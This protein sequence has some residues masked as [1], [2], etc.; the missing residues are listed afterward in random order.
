M[1]VMMACPSLIRNSTP[2]IKGPGA[3]VLMAAGASP[4][5]GQQAKGRRDNTRGTRLLT[6]P[7]SKSVW[8]SP[9]PRR[10][11]CPPHGSHR[12][13]QS[14][15]PPTPCPHAHI[16]QHTLLPNTPLHP[17]SLSFMISFTN[18]LIAP[19][20]THPPVL[21]SF[22][23]LPSPPSAHLLLNLPSFSISCYVRWK[24]IIM[25][26]EGAC[27]CCSAITMHTH[28]HTCMQTLIWGVLGWGLIGPGGFGWG[29]L[30]HWFKCRQYFLVVLV[31]EGVAG[32]WGL[33]FRDAG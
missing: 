5:V 33:Y 15:Y 8:H 21:P 19:F 14:C 27:A 25:C 2:L 12:Q 18:Q 28:K 17:F 10:S 23:S 3:L 11:Y 16:Q 30:I 4:G 6:V 20:L 26:K 24:S 31:E 7:Q 22:P 32:G 29:T 9:Y 13:D 1:I